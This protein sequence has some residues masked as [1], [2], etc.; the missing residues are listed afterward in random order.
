MTP[1]PRHLVLN[2]LLG[3]GGEALS[4]RTAVAACALFG[5]RENSVRVALARLAASGLVTP[6]GRGSY[7]LG[8]QAAGLAADV[9]QWR[10]A[11]SR[12]RE[13]RG[14]WIAVHTPP[15]AAPGTSA[16][17]RS[18]RRARE[19]ALGLLG[20]RE[21]D[22]GLRLRPDNL[23]GGA[24]A[25]RERL[26]RLGLGGDACVFVACDLD[27]VRERRARTLWDGAALNLGYRATQQ[28]L[29][30]W[31]AR[32]ERLP[33]ADAARQSFTLG[34]DAIRQ[35]VFDPLLPS[36]LVDA[37]A[38]QRFIDAVVRF[39]AAGQAIWHRFR[40]ETTA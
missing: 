20:L 16:T 17:G 32:A 6:A 33:L 11:G 3:A 2:L 21:L 12:L 29:E 39:D 34:H 23:A 27:P 14:D 1:N 5:L 36:P 30:R 19:R 22:R 8:P 38:R 4:A 18:A 35:L 15:R 7:R 25:V 40:K 13:W 10:D 28:R 24:V 31:L 9:A 37:G 26:A